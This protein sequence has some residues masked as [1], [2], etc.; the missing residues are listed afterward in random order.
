MIPRD[1]ETA[2]EFRHP[3]WFVRGELSIHARRLLEETGRHSVI[4]D[5]PGRRDVLHG[6]LTGNKVVVR[7][8]GCDGHP[9]DLLR[10][11]HWVRKLMEWRAIGVAEAY[12]YVH[13][14]DEAHIPLLIERFV[15][16]CGRL[17]LELPE[18]QVPDA[19]TT[20]QMTLF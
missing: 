11:E 20:G 8:A 18:W 9:S 2:V 15:E 10:L 13:S 6:T 16:T 1:F 17:G 3:A 4:T 12:F 19:P 7:F 14:P 5:V